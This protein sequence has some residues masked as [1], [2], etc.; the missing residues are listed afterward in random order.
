MT[1]PKHWVQDDPGWKQRRASFDRVAERYDSYRP[2]YP[3]E[4]VEFVLSSSQLPPAGRILEIGC[5]TGIATRKF[6]S[7]GYSMVCVEPGANLAA[8]AQKR[9][10]T[11]HQVSFEVSTFED[12]SDGGQRFDLVLSAQAFHWI[13]TDIAYAKSAR[14]LQPGGCLALVWNMYPDPQGTIWEEMRLI[15]DRLWPSKYEKRL[16]YLELAERR[17]EE[18]AGSGFFDP[19]QTGKFP[20]SETYT[21]ERY[22]GLLS[23]YSDHIALESEQRNKL[24]SAIEDLVESNDGQIEKPYVAYAYVALKRPGLLV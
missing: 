8:L 21:T 17:A 2:G 10:G 9:L 18:I 15:Y 19:A 6:A 20:W 3:D 12:W 5:G 13:P 14:I 24:F 11:G 7:L 16:T 23:T 1:K 4:L 22:L